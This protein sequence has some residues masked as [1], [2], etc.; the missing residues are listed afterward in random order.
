MPIVHFNL[1]DG[2]QI[3]V[4]GEANTPIMI[5]AKKQGITG[6]L[7]E[8]GGA[9]CCATC[10]VHLDPEWTPKVPEMQD[11]ERDMLEFA[12]DVDDN[13][14][15]SCQLK[16]TEALDGIVVNVPESQY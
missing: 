13:S 14:R 1:H 15:L 10:H 16:L 11:D 8:C 6:I 9:C 2:N 7:A 4:E 3:S 5:L 12:D